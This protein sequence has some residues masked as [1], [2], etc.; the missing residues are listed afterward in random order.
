MKKTNKIIII[1]LI[2]LVLFSLTVSAAKY[3]PSNPNF[4]SISSTGNNLKDF[5]S[6]NLLI[7][8]QGLGKTF[9]ASEQQ[10]YISLKTNNEIHWA[11]IDLETGKLFA[12]G[13]TANKVVYGASI[14]KPF[15]AAALLEKDQ[16]LDSFTW[17]SIFSLIVESKNPDWTPLEK[18]AGGAKEVEKFVQKMGYSKTEGSR[19]GNKVNALELSQFLYDSYQNHYDGGEALFKIMSACAT[20]AKKGQKYLPKN[21]YVGGKTGTHEQYYHMM[22][23]INY[24]NHYYGI[25]VLGET[26]SHEDIA[27]MVGGL[28]KEYVAKET[29]SN[30]NSASPSGV[31]NA[32]GVLTTTKSCSSSVNNLIKYPIDSARATKYGNEWVKALNKAT[33]YGT[34][35]MGKLASNGGTDTKGLSEPGRLTIIF[36]PCTTDF[37]KPVEIM[38]Y[39]HGIHSFGFSDKLGGGTSFNGFNKRIAHQLKTLVD[40]GRNYVLVF[41]ELP[42][43]SGDT[44]EYTTYRED[45]KVNQWNKKLWDYSKGDSDLVQLHNDVLN[46][47]K[48]DLGGSSLQVGYISMTG[49]SAGGRPMAQAA[50]LKL[51]GKVG[52]NGVNKITFSDADYGSKTK[53][54]YDNYVKNR[55]DVELNMLVQDPSKKGAHE[56]T[57]YSILL[58]KKIGGTTTSGWFAEDVNWE[59]DVLE[60]YKSPGAKKGKVFKVPGHPNINY[61]PLNKGHGGIGAMSLT[62]VSGNEIPSSYADSSVQRGGQGGAT[63][64]GGQTQTQTPTPSTQTPGWIPNGLPKQQ[65]EIDEVWSK[66]LGPL[67]KGNKLIYNPSNGQWEKFQE[68]YYTYG[69]IS[70]GTGTPSSSQPSGQQPSISSTGLCFP[71]ISNSFVKISD[72]WGDDRDS[73]KG[74]DTRCHAGIDIYSKSPGNVVAIADGTVTGIREKWYTCGD[75]WGIETEGLT[76]KHPISAV[77]VFHPS[78]GKTVSY[79]EIDHNKVEVKRGNPITKGQKLGVASY[80]DMLH[81]ELYDG[82]VSGPEQW[83][84]PSGQS[85][86]G[87]K[88]CASQY[89]STKPKNLLD[90]TDLINQLKSQNSFC[91]TTTGS[92]PPPPPPPTNR[93]TPTTCTYLDRAW[94]DGGWKNEKNIKVAYSG[95]KGEQIDPS[96]SECTLCNEDQVP[97]TVDGKTIKVCWKYANQV[98]NALQKIVDSGFPI[99][100]IIG[101]REGRTYGGTDFG[102]H[103]YG[104]AID[105]NREINGLYNKCNVWDVNKCVLGAGGKSNAKRV[106][107]V[108]GTITKS[109]PAYQQLTSIGWKWG[110]DWGKDNKQKDYMHFSLSGK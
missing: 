28:F 46:K 3:D 53:K 96:G 44:G 9:G 30:S 36:A 94:I 103:P 49:Q 5:D 47:V 107:S 32:V 76:G 13:A 51:L 26:K 89:R 106:A 95:I 59:T 64:S 105:I 84:P 29:N 27:V 86:K 37:N 98:Q 15:I 80:C 93:V 67:I 75:G 101:F 61:V 16:N 38:Y 41:P 78:L 11:V 22:A 109:S 56:P 1:S 19:H 24:N 39:F 73:D 108:S 71:L 25:V 6:E 40:N 92:T 63:Y 69:L 57:K 52:D 104:V 65:E 43:S 20:A 72:N 12:Q 74:K 31:N 58:V 14:T 97:I 8:K 81:F 79:A 88:K 33:V 66:T 45:Y 34:S 62:W 42:W 55:P 100:D 23:T 68:T 85:T 70:S 87:I 2:L 82:K 50:K 4:F 90:P 10:K 21:V 35:W 18:Q 83:W 48:T 99:K 91:G 54:V 7:A 17:S 60:K 110:G 77:L 102:L